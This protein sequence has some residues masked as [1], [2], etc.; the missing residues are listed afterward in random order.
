MRV[1]R[2]LTLAALFWTQ[3]CL[4]QGSLAGIRVEPQDLFLTQ[5]HQTSLSATFNGSP[6]RTVW[7]SDNTS[8]ATVD[9]DGLVTASA[10]N[11]GTATI[12]AVSG[13]F[14][15]S[16]VVR[17]VLPPTALSLDTFS[18]IATVGQALSLQGQ[19]SN[20]TGQINGSDGSSINVQAGLLVQ[21]V[22]RSDFTTYSLVVTN[23]AGDTAT[24]TAPS[25]LGFPPPVITSFYPSSQFVSRGKSVNLIGSFMG[26]GQLLE[27]GG[28]VLP[29]SSPFAI[30]VFP[31][32]GAST[33]GLAVQNQAGAALNA[34]VTVQGVPPPV[35]NSFSASASHVASGGTVTFLAAFSNPGGTATISPGN[36]P[37]TSGSPTSPATVAA[38]TGFALTV[39]NQAGTS[40]VA[41]TVVSVP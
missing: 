30:Q 18:P 9:A 35:I 34:T 24:V 37:V 6:V 32:S 1:R 31:M 26:S 15:N 40:A 36:I 41:T 11:S 23:L 33:Y 25:V 29:V 27:P 2:M 4:A 3:S 22:A 5:A 19:F 39:T 12:T 28:T 17:V 16:T 7:M 8:I 10:S 14:R 38:T 20:G 21:A 13:P